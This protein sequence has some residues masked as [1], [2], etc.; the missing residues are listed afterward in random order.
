MIGD[1]DGAPDPAR[2][3]RLGAHGRLRRSPR[4][5][6][7][8]D[9]GEQPNGGLERPG[10]LGSARHQLGQ[11]AA[12]SCRRLQGGSGERGDV[13]LD[14]AG[15]DARGAAQGHHREEGARPAAA[16]DEL[17]AA[18]AEHH[19]GV[20]GTRHH[21]C[22]G[23][24]QLLQRGQ[25]GGLG[26]AGGE[27]DP[28]H[29]DGQRVGQLPGGRRPRTW[30][31]GAQGGRDA[32]VVPPAHPCADTYHRHGRIIAESGTFNVDRGRGRHEDEAFGLS[33][34]RPVTSLTRGGRRSLCHPYTYRHIHDLHGSRHRGPA[35]RR[36]ATSL[37]EDRRDRR[38]GEP[39]R[40]R[41]QGARRHHG[42]PAHGPL[43][44]SP[45]PDRRLIPIQN[46]TFA[47]V[48]W[49]MDEDPAGLEN[50]VE[51]PPEIDIPYRGQERHPVPSREVARGAGRSEGAAPPG[52]GG[53]GGSAASR[54]R[55]RW[56]TRSWPAPVGCSRWRRSPRRARSGCSCP[57]PSCA[58]RARSGPRSLE[59]NRRRE[60]GGRRPLFA[61]RG[62][63]GSRWSR[64][65][66]RARQPAVP[67]A[68][69][70]S[71]AAEAGRA[72]L[73]AL[74]R[75]LRECDPPTVE[76]VVC[77]MLEKLGLPRAEG[78]QARPRARHLHRPAP[79]GPRGRPPRD[80]HPAQLGRGGA[81]RRHRAAPRSG[82][83]RC[84]DRGRW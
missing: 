10:V 12:E 41:R 73:A 9:P 14:V 80:P 76:H 26:A 13:D 83:L 47:L 34:H 39:A 29:L 4:L 24:Q 5:R 66:S 46:G 40:P 52:G 77:R 62:R 31:A 82:A 64:S 71:T 61:G 74:R 72:G 70:P 79:P 21:G 63:T 42:G 44:A 28:V 16:Q 38:P 65:P 15:Q 1:L 23:P 75:R 35:A 67:A 57:T 60:S 27:V 58:T 53:A 37:Q 51:P 30:G 69:A 8:L 68:R 25:E 81:A 20:G 59:D 54:R 55:P 36:E 19:G 50:L 2:L 56:P 22:D 6:S 11:V 3:R 7:G 78:G 45:R 33:A 18:L 48:E 43:P 84:A 32:R 49:G 17:Q